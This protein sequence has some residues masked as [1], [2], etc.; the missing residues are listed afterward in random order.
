MAS[1]QQQG[2]SS[3]TKPTKALKLGL[4]GVG[5]G[6]AEMLPAMEAMEEIDLFA[7]ADVVPET[8]ERFKARYPNARVYDS[9][10][11]IGRAHV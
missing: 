5:V 1:T 3:A 10:E 8:R 9:A 6:A 7:A 11:E 4:I 2:S